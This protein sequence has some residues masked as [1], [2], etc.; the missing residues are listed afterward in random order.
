MVQLQK[1]YRPGPDAVKWR[2]E[3]HGGD[4]SG[5][6]VKVGKGSA[7]FNSIFLRT[8]SLRELN[9]IKYQSA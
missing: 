8:Q 6:K 3:A 5:W 7:F 9:R 2:W 4:R 1:V